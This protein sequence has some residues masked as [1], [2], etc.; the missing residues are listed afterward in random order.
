[1]IRFILI[2]FLALSVFS[3]GSFKEKTPT[4]DNLVGKTWVLTNIGS[5]STSRDVQTTLEFSEDN[6]LSGSGGCNR[7]FGSYELNEG[8]F[9]VSGIG[10]TR[11]MCPENA[12]TQEQNYILT[13]EGANAI[14]MFGDNLVIYSGEVFQKLKFSP[15]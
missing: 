3:C 13:L 11:K 8:S 15:Q 2:S 10:S 4:V 1:M 7:Y 14:K 6:Q 9:S 12:M 5:L